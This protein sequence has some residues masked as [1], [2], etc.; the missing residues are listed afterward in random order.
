MSIE[1]RAR[2]RVAASQAL[3]DHKGILF[4]DW[5]NWVEHME[6]IVSA[7]EAEIIDW[8]EEIERYATAHAASALRAIPSE[9]RSEASRANGRKH[10]KRE[11]ATESDS[12]AKR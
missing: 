9:K 2:D 4:H 1:S 10:K 5:P 7:P 12:E 6:W 8:A 3:K 11:I